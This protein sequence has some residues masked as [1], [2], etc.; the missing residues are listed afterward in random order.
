MRIGGKS[1]PESVFIFFSMG[2]EPRPLSM[3]RKCSTIEPHPWSLS[4]NFNVKRSQRKPSTHTTVPWLW[5]H[6]CMP[7]VEAPIS[8]APWQQRIREIHPVRIQCWQAPGKHVIPVFITGAR[9]WQLICAKCQ[10][11]FH[12]AGRQRQFCQA[13]VTVHY[14]GGAENGTFGMLDAR[15]GSRK[16]HPRGCLCQGDTLKDIVCSS[17]AQLCFSERQICPPGCGALPGEPRILPSLCILIP[18]LSAHFKKQKANWGPLPPMSLIC[19]GESIMANN[20]RKASPG[21]GSSVSWFYADEITMNHTSKCLWVSPISPGQH[22]KRKK[23]SV[24]GKNSSSRPPN[25]PSIWDSYH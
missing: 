16:P 9:E 3:L 25:I 17:W 1:P 20:D 19:S 6:L 2:H 15:E 8:T 14:P 11:L 5:F 10:I 22:N 18:S 23:K 12:W 21:R 13:K 24:L 4:L 7:Q